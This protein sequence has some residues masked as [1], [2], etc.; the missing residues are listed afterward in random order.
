MSEPEPIISLSL[1]AS[2][3]SSP[4]AA[5]QRPAAETLQ[6]R[7]A[8]HVSEAPATGTDSQRCVACSKPITGTYFHV[9]GK[10]VCPEC[11]T[12]IESRQ[13]APSAHS[14]LKAFFYGLG[15][16]AAGSALYSIVAIVTGLEFAL[17]AILIG[18]MVAKAIRHASG[19]LG[20]R[21]QQILAVLLTYFAI[22]TSYIPVGI[23]QYAKH[24]RQPTESTQT[25]TSSVAS[26][27]S[28][29]ASGNARRP[30]MSAGAALL[31]ILAL[32][33]A[34]PFLSISSFGGILSLV[35]IF[36]GLQRAWRLTGRTQIAV[37]GPYQLGV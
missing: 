6:F 12:A 17:I 25:V 26:G 14:L 23:Y 20:G 30:R 8:E 19:G 9:H 16:A 35:I 15:A 22:T 34:A 24:H 21:P 32:A 27:G 7:R 13:K 36:F 11:A 5:E 2:P 37:M 33:L 1:N 18:Y 10:V 28:A 31:A 4:S 29:A 3:E